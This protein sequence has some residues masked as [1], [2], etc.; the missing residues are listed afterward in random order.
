MQIGCR[1]IRGLDGCAFTGGSGYK[2]G[3]KIM[4]LGVGDGVVTA[5]RS[6]G[7]PRCVDGRFDEVCHDEGRAAEQT[8]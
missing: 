1:E 4:D 6:S 5:S 8:Q 3:R 7:F 2:R